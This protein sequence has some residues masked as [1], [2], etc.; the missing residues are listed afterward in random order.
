LEKT[1]IKRPVYENGEWKVGQEGK[2]VK[3]ITGFDAN[4]LYLGCIGNEMPCGRLKYEEFQEE[5]T[6]TYLKCDFDDKELAKEYGTP[7]SKIF[8]N[9]VLDNLTK[10]LKESGR[11]NKTGRGLID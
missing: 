4:A 10:Y 2:T 3:N 8:V 1:K 6:T 9:G 11:I 7:K 5:I